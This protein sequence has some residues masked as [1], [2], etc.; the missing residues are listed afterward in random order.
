MS[1]SQV[2]HSDPSSSPSQAQ[3]QDLK[4]G[5]HASNADDAVTSSGRSDSSDWEVVQ[6]P[7]VSCADFVQLSSLELPLVVYLS[8]S[9]YSPH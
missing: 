3:L 4:L 6:H 2:S 7:E 8:L 5:P 1:Q 9:A